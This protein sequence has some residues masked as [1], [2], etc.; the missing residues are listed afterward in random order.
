MDNWAVRGATGKANCLTSKSCEMAALK[1]TLLILA[2][3]ILYVVG[4]NAIT[5][6]PAL[7]LLPAAAFALLYLRSRSTRLL[8]AAI[9]WVIYFFYEYGMWLRVLCSGECNIRVDFL[10]VHPF[11]FWVSVAGIAKLLRSAPGSRQAP[12]MREVLELRTVH[13]VLD[14]ALHRSVFM[15]TP[16]DAAKLSQA[17]RALRIS[18]RERPL[19][20]GSIG[21]RMAALAQALD[22]ASEQSSAV[23]LSRDDTEALHAQIGAILADLASGSA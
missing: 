1:L 21:A 20:D 23:S 14:N 17:S 16:G 10:L 12:V 11:L 18:A 8:I 7:A 3:L 5:T 2:G 15:L 22:I 9:A 4:A 6:L 19:S 13:D